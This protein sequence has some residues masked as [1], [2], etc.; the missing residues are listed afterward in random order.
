[1]KFKIITITVIGNTDI[2]TSES[3]C[4]RVFNYYHHFPFNDLN[5]YSII[6]F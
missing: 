3:F 1:V 2:K 4:F 6:L 5:N